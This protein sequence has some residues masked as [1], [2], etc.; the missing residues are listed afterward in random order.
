MAISLLSSISSFQIKYQRPFS[1]VI[2]V[3]SFFTAIRLA[4]SQTSVNNCVLDIQSS[5]SGNNSTCTGGNWDGFINNNCCES[6]FDGYL[7]ALGQR[8]NQSGKIFLNSTEQK[9]CLNSMKGMDGNVLSC[10]IEKLNSGEGG[11][12]DYSV[13]DV[14][15]NLGNDLRKLGEDCEVLG[16]SNMGCI[17]CFRRWE[18]MSMLANNFIKVE[19]DV[20][21][22]AVLVSLT[23]QRIDDEKWIQAVYKCLGDRSLSLGKVLVASQLYTSA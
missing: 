23:S 22:F 4:F 14:A 3:F 19:T 11:C 9:E 13:S 12:S 5:S 7:H 15:N 16:E 2:L 8:A 21:R 20:C 1:S 6:S 18:M 17:A 10:G